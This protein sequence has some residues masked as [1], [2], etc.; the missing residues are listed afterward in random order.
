MFFDL[1]VPLPTPALIPQTTQSSKKGKQKQQTNVSAGTTDNGPPLFFSP[2]QIT[3][4]EARI[5]ILIHLGYTVLALAQTV[6][7]KVD[8]RTHVD[9][10]HG[11]VPKLKRRRGIA[12]LKR[13][14]V[15]LDEDSEKGNGVNPQSATLLSNY[16]IIS[17]QPTSQA[18]FSQACLTHSI[19]SPHTA[20]VISV[21]VTLPR[22]PFHLKHTLIRAALK[23][24]AVFE[25]DYAGAV[26]V[27]ADRRNWWGGARE[28]VRVTK[29]KGVLLSGGVSEDR[30]I[31]APKDAA[32]LVTLLG[33]PQ[34]LSHDSVTQTPKSVVLRAQSRKTYRAVL[35]EPKLILPAN[36][37]QTSNDIDDADLTLRAESQVTRLEQVPSATIS[38]VEPEVTTPTLV[39]PLPPSHQQQ[40]AVK[41]G[42]KRQ[43]DNS[44]RPGGERSQ[45]K[46][47]K[48]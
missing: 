37:V 47:K 31:R 23:N 20:H 14:T 8:P 41:N 10:L 13:L 46:K 29:G 19:P 44:Q 9:W 21:P 22:L 2:A 1:N 26:G 25:I 17:L 36:I 28:L 15:L 40:A 6:Q 5:D 39:E 12:I 24:G 35:S 30:E 38:S 7:T 4:I 48:K 42:K 27:E 16:D 32:N 45:K 43:H 11:L 18:S 3:A 34:N 33:I